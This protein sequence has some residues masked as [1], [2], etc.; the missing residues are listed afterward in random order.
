MFKYIL[1]QRPPSIGTHPIKD[2]VSVEET[3]FRNRNAYT[4]TYSSELSVEDVKRYELTPDYSHNAVPN[5]HFTFGG[6]NIEEVA[7][8]TGANEI[9]T[10]ID[11][12]FYDTY[13][14][15]GWFQMVN[16]I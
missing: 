14:F 8:V 15:L 1:T 13:S 9:T 5:K 2:L 12:N 10:E 7:A 4:L 3:T 11:G 6:K 16:G